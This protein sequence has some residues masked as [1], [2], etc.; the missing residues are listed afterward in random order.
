MRPARLLWIAKVL[1]YR[2]RYR[3]AFSIAGFGLSVGRRVSIV[4]RPPGSVRIGAS[5]QLRDGCE[6]SAL[7]GAIRIAPNV[8]FNRHCTIVA[9]EAVEIGSDCIFGPNVAI[10]D[11]DHGYEDPERPIWAQELRTGAISIGSNVWVGANAV[12][13]RG[14]TIGDRVVVGANSVVTNDLPGGGVYA[15]SPAALVRSL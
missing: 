10:Y 11:H 12:V 13:T 7:G 15:G 3:D 6:L 2:L 14:V 8:F 5:V 4:V 9:Q 1:A